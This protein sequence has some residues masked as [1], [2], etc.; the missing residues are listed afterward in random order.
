MHVSAPSIRRSLA[1]WLAFPLAFLVP[2][3]AAV[4][5][6]LA[7]RPAFD[8][9]DHSLD[10]TALAL[11]GLVHTSSGEPTVRVTP[12]L[13][14]ALRADRFDEVYWVALG[15][16]GNALGGDADLA[17]V[18]GPREYTP[19]RFTDSEFHNVPV[20]V[21]IHVWKCMTPGTPKDG[22]MCEVRVAES[23]NKHHG[24][25]RAVLAAATSAMVLEALVLALMGWVG[26]GRS[27]RPVERLSAD[28]ER[29]SP[30]QL[31]AV[32]Q[33]DI[34]REVAPLIAALNGLFGRVSAASAAEKAFLADAAHQLRT[35]LTAL[36]TETELALM[37]PHPAQIDGLLRRLHLG[38]NRAARLA[39]QLLAQA[40]AEHDAK[41]APAERFDLKFIA[42][43]TIEEWVARSV[44]AGV[45]LGFELETASVDGRGYLLREMLANL[46]DNALLY[47]GS[48]ARVTVRTRVADTPAGPRSVLEVEDN[49]PGIPAT[50]RERAFERFQRGSVS[51]PGGSGLGLSIVRDIAHH[52]D[53]HIELLDG[54]GGVGLCVRVTFPLTLERSRRV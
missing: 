11:E 44:E 23:L 51:G 8:S 37:E 27:L 35:P 36:R 28:I 48:G 22:G 10:G 19:W 13:D 24:V 39:H 43:E 4:F 53:A 25:Q 5:Y 49:G 31:G 14:R 20:R 42:S 46:L 33:P 30:D 47:A 21:A 26:I 34:P 38:A 29:R 17:T 7:L 1:I 50:D 41:N 52:H 40:R 18:G 3:T 6:S 2:L 9:L 54:P 15:P 45:D 16:A 32:V 12:D